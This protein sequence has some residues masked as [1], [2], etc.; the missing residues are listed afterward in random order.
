MSETYYSIKKS[1]L[2][3]IADAVRRKTG[4]T[5]Q[6]AVSGLAE[7]ISGIETGG[8]I[9][10]TVLT[11]SQVNAQAAAYLAATSGYTASNRSSVSVMG[12][13]EDYTNTTYEDPMGATI[14]LNETGTLYFLDETDG[15]NSWRET[16]SASGAY[17]CYNLIPNHTYRWW[18]KNSGGDTVQNGRIRL[19]G[20]LRMI[21]GSNQYL[22]NM[23]DNGG[24]SCDGGTIKYNLLIRG[25]TLA[26]QSGTPYVTAKD[27]M[28]LHD[29]LGVRLEVDM[30]Y[31]TTYS[32][33]VL[34]ADVARY[35]PYSVS[36]YYA[37]MLK[38]TGT[39]YVATAKM[40]EKIMDYV[41]SG[42]AVY[43]HCWSGAD[44][45][46]TTA[47]LLLGIL[48]VAE[49]DID[50][51]YELTCFY[52]G[53]DHTDRKRTNTYYNA[54]FTYLYTFDGD[55]F[56]DKVLAWM[57]QAGVHLDKINRFRAAM[58]SGTARRHCTGI[59]RLRRP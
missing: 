38:L 28:Y 18:L 49:T 44:R 39:N 30:Q 5:A 19:T 32:A 37:D 23:R 20:T 16:V 21:Y 31:D 1:T 52:G 57:V 58:S 55:S 45:T 10:N 29:T 7:A 40:L 17:T 53:T 48:G 22:H 11:A 50:K 33:S 24:W 43:Y 34:G 36:V 41:S 2:T 42:R 6:I 35:V 27:I 3:G 56:R 59:F 54:V 9:D 47:V 8:G 25:G 15:Q 46:G 51:D 26:H 4:D 13:Y 14:T 12:D